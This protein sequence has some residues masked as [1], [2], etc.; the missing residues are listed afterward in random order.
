MVV[1]VGVEEGGSLRP[2][3]GRIVGTE[4]GQGGEGGE[5]KDEEGVGKGL[6]M[7]IFCI[8]EC[9]CVCVFVYLSWPVNKPDYLCS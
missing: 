5:T 2:E 7:L 4:G 6:S 9:V 8:S 3:E 1:G